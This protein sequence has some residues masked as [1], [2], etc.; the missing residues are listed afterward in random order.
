MK[1]TSAIFALNDAVISMSV[2]FVVPFGES[3]FF[4]TQV[5]ND[6]RV[7]IIDANSF[8]LDVNFDCNADDQKSC[9]D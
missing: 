2:G 7:E 6:F 9:G 8:A 3:D 5:A 4:F 1:P